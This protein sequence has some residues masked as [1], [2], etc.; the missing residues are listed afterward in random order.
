M[1]SEGV[2]AIEYG[3]SAEDIARTTHAHVR[4]DAFF[5]SFDPI[6]MMYPAYAQRSFQGGCHGCVWQAH[7]YVIPLCISSRIHKIDFFKPPVV[8]Q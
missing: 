7:P 6:L 2:L 5:E 1:I 3:A 8:F 4:F